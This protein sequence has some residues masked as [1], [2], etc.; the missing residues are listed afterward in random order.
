MIVARLTN[1]TDKTLNNDPDFS[2][3][4]VPQHARMSKGSLTMAWWSLCSAMIWLLVSATLAM[5]YGTAN[6]VTGLVLSVFT[7]GIINSVISRYAI[8]TGL[9]VGLFSRKVYGKVGEILA[10]GI[11]FSIAIYYCV[12]EGSVIAVA[13]QHYF[14]QL[15]LWHAYLI[16]V[17]YSVPL[18]FGGVSQW[19][20]KLNGALLPFYYI[21]LFSAVALTVS[22][23][24]YTDQWLNMGPENAQ[25]NSDWW[26]CYSYFMGLWVMMMFTWD[27]A[28]FGKIKDIKYLSNI[29]FGIPFYLFTYL[30]NGVIGI[31]L[32]AT[33]PTEESLSEI[34]IVFALLKLMGLSGLLFIWVSQTRINTA[35]FQLATVNLQAFIYRV[36]KLK[37]SKIVVAIL[38]GAVVFSLML[39]D[40]F[41]FI[42][43]A[44]A[45]QSIFVVSWV[46]IALTYIFINKN[47]E[48]YDEE[49]IQASL[50]Q[51]NV[52]YAGIFAWGISSVTG[53]LMLNS[54]SEVSQY[55]S[56]AT[57]II[58]VTTYSL[59][60]GMRNKADIILKEVEYVED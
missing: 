54:S 3:S 56:L 18:V 50:Q 29:N 46:V 15:E 8:R 35:N 31:F 40:V 47:K 48:T 43:L 57:I 42:L 9:S 6:A 10:T 12:F 1:S 39:T 41:S 60:Q 14:T 37:L 17:L 36:F 23:Y 58:A 49:T 13:I 32:V 27:Y 38:V 26:Q 59:L 44:L 16:V 25:L 24:G 20:D 28:R 34:S 52:K 11:F 51:P 4:V 53:V 19:L 33:I 30:L 45:Y 7:Y 5:N 21:G 22:Q 55:A 2:T